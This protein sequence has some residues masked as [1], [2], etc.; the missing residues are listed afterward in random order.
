MT[1]TDQT[2]ADE[3]SSRAD[4][5]RW[6]LPSAI[7]SGEGDCYAAEAVQMPTELLIKILDQAGRVH[8]AG[9]KLFG[10]LIAEPAAPRH[11]YHPTDVV[12]FNPQTNHR[13]DPGMREVFEAQGTYFREFDDAGFVADPTELLHFCRA[14]EDSGREI[15][16]PFHVHRRQ[17]ANFSMIDYRLHNPAFAWHLIVSLRDP[18]RA[19]VQPFRVHKQPGDFGI[20]EHDH[21]EGG[22][23]AYDGPEVHP[24]SLIVRESP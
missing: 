6:N 14:I 23:L 4:H 22:E 8:R 7:M 19:A 11:P 5:K 1:M 20:T 13:N 3:V 18:R 2:S 16:A 24:I 15:V 10:L 9:L 17:P 12:F 21:R